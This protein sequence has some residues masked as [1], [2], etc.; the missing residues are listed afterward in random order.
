MK[1]EGVA[2][3]FDAVVVGAGVAGL[4]AA[5]FLAKAGRSVALVEVD[6]EA[7]GLCRTVR[8]GGFSWDLSLYGLR[9]CGPGGPLLAL[10]DELGIARQVPMR[11]ARTS[12]LVKLGGEDFPVTAERDAMIGAANRIEPGSA[13]RLGPF[14]ERI[15]AFNPVRDYG[16]LSRLT[17]AEVAVAAG[18]GRNLLAALSA[19]LMVS[20]GL[21]PQ[22]ASA[23]FAFLKY[24]LILSGGVSRPEGGAKSLVRALEELFVSSGGSLFLGERVEAVAVEPDGAKRVV[25]AKRSFLA[26]ALVL[27]IDATTALSWLAPALPER[28]RA[29]PALLTPA[30]SATLLFCSTPGATLRAVGLESAPQVIVVRDPDLE[31]L[32]RALRRGIAAET[33]GIVG[34][35]SPAAW[36]LPFQ[37][38]Q[39]QALSV[40][41]LA[42]FRPVDDDPGRGVLLER[43]RRAVPGLSGDLTAHAA[44]GPRDLVARTGNRAG[45]FCGWEMG[46]ER[47][48]AAR[49]PAKVPIPGVHLAGHWTDPGPSVLNAAL[50]GR[51]AARSILG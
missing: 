30:L 22:R 17:F 40:F 36:H 21:P 11:H 48:G 12:Y 38:D 4:T 37:D 19:P 6:A 31:A 32:Y 27:A 14:L 25:T 46:P 15:Q 42:P 51:T 35:T 34:L 8:A 9:G 1:P 7:G 23:Y 2:R 41:S 24:R 29:K 20:L 44:W 26:G 49:L 5:C 45:S 33:E 47:Y 16:A 13:E 28:L 50:S 10:L 39:R 18:I 3:R 43:L